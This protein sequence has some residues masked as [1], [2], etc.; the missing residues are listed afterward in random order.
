MKK[1][2]M[3][4]LIAGG[5]MVFAAEPNTYQVTHLGAQEVGIR[6]LGGRKMS[7]RLVGDMAILTCAAAPAKK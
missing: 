4:V 7:E 1:V 3:F 5:L 6:C 2:L